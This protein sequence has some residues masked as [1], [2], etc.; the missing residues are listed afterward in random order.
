[1]HK[2]LKQSDEC[3]MR[4]PMS[5]ENT[6]CFFGHRKISVTDDLKSRLYNEIEN[7]ITTDGINTFL[8]GSKSQFDDLCYK[9]IT[10]LKSKYPNI[11]RVYVRAENEYIDGEGS[12]AYRE[13]LMEFYEHTYH[14]ESVS[15]AGKAVYVKRNQHMIDE[16]SVCVC[17]YDENYLP[18][19]RK[20]SRSD[21]FDYQP[22][23]GTGIAY[24]Y[25][26]KKKKKIINIFSGNPKI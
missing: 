26:V 15:G 2:C 16:S 13:G 6:A 18:A 25:A 17:F 3:E 14:P 12:R 24:Q 21:L 5:I 4:N 1:M 10:D 20:Q 19:R 9:V 22:A 8:F 7:L 23:S 11:Q